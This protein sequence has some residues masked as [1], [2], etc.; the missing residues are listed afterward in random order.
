MPFK[1]VLFEIDYFILAFAVHAE[2]KYAVFG[3]PIPF[4]P[5]SHS[6]FARCPGLVTCYCWYYGRI[7]PGTHVASRG[8]SH[9][10]LLGLCN[11]SS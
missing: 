1:L 4:A 8:Q 9:R 3:V 2:L 7:P 5:S 6:K 11:L 10:L